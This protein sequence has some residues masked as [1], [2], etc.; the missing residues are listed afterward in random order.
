MEAKLDL[1]GLE[2]PYL[3]TAAMLTVVMLGKFLRHKLNVN[4]SRD[5]DILCLVSV[6]V[7]FCC[8]GTGTLLTASFSLSFFVFFLQGNVLTDNQTLLEIFGLY[9]FDRETNDHLLLNYRLKE[10]PVLK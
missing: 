1:K 5:V 10:A 8:C 3:R 2:K 7:C 4:P 6:L 9:W